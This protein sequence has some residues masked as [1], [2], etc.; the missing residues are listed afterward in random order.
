MSKTIQAGKVFKNYKVLCEWLGVT[1]TK[2]K[3]RGYHFKEFERYCTYHK[4]GQ[5]IIVDEVF[6]NPVDKADNR[7]NNGANKYID[8]MIPL[9]EGYIGKSQQTIYTTS[10]NLLS[11]IGVVHTD[12]VNLYSNATKVAT[13]ITNITNIKVTPRTLEDFSNN[14]NRTMHNALRSALNR[15][16]KQ[17]KIIYKDI[18]FIINDGD[19]EPHEADKYEL[20]IIEE[21]EKWVLDDMFKKGEIKN[22]SKNSIFS[23]KQ[24]NKFYNLLDKC[25]LEDGIGQM[26]KNIYIKNI[27]CTQMDTTDNLATLRNKFAESVEHNMKNI[28]WKDD[29]LIWGDEVNVYP[30][31]GIYG[32]SKVDKTITYM[33]MIHK[34]IWEELVDKELEHDEENIPF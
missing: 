22:P 20:D 11:A 24:R 15:L 2:G 5:K 12:Y 8:D 31:K 23:F 6:D 30:Y 28:H 4:E 32:E 19:T 21:N 7:I 14:I 9:L 17:G 10:N 33:F 1:P 26:W 16:H 29:N 25:L 3:G 27:S 13:T 34:P 18:T